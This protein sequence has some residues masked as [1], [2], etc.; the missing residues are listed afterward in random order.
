MRAGTQTARDARLVQPRAARH[1]ARQVH[2]DDRRGTPVPK[3]QTPQPQPQTSNP[4][5]QNPKPNPQNPNPKPQPPNPFPDEAGRPADL[6]ALDPDTPA[7]GQEERAS[8]GSN[9]EGRAM[10][11]ACHPLK[12]NSHEVPRYNSCTK[13]G[14]L[15]FWFKKSV[16]TI[17]VDVL[18]G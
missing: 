14:T 11:F 13:P 4:K 2:D 6:E 5:T 1:L 12:H 7:S 17:H 9:R 15:L 18:D 16:C 10:T 8:G 3:P